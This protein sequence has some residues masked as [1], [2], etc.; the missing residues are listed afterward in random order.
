MSPPRFASAAQGVILNAVKNLLFP[1]VT[2]SRFFARLRMT[3]GRSPG[4][5]SACVFDVIVVG[6]GMAGCAAAV[7]SARLGCRTLLVEQF[8]FLGGWATAALVNPFMTHCASDGTPLVAGLFDEI[9]SRL[10]EM[11]GLLGNSFDS[12]CMKFVLQEMTLEAGVRLRLHSIFKRARFADD[13]SIRVEL[14]SKSGTRHSEQREES[15]GPEIL[16]AAQNDKRTQTG[17]QEFTCRRLIDCSGDGD[18][19]VSLGAAFEMGD[20]DGLHQATTLMFDM[21]GV[22]LVRT[23]TY[24]R[25][26]PDQMRFPKLP[27]D[28]DPHQLAQGIISVAG[29]YDL[30]AEARSRGEYGAPGDLIF[31][32]GRP[33][34]GEVV[35]NTTHIG[36]IDGTN[37]EDL[38]RAEIEGR[39]QMMSIVAFVRRYVPGFEEAYLLRSAAHVGVR[40][41]RRI[42]GD[43]VF[44]AEDVVRARKFPDSICRLAYPVDVHSGE[45]E[46]YIKDEERKSN[47]SVSGAP[48]PGDWY[49]I[50]C[51][52]LFPKG[53]ENVLVAGRCV[54][55]TQAGQGAIRIMPAC[56]AMGQAAG[57]AAA[58]SVQHGVSP[59]VLSIDALLEALKEQGASI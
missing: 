44:S 29:Y 26:H 47:E 37:A 5:S 53:I 15:R 46:G 52:C 31:Y 27:P 33:A 45:G 43:Y 34:R 42:I 4:M 11:G 16:R 19:A 38:T 13:G 17:T 30:I 49:E 24:V 23:M 58:L 22:D 56:V 59:R 7:S 28:A 6:G 32:I 51:R 2:N 39:R 41:T 36:H 57:T 55:S 35:F 1:G 14:D 12:E 25:D 3:E 9:R 50:P 8:G 48:P 10:S 54:S 21:G 18:A 40:E 20:K